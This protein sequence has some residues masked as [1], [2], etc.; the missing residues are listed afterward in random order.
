MRQEPKTQ[1]S[2]K[3]LPEGPVSTRQ[4]ASQT[5]DRKLPPVSEFPESLI[6][7]GAGD[8]SRISQSVQQNGQNLIID[9]WIFLHVR[10]IMLPCHLLLFLVKLRLLKNLEKRQDRQLHDQRNSRFAFKMVLQVTLPVSVL[11]LQR[12]AQEHGTSRTSGGKETDAD[13]GSEDHRSERDGRPE[14][15][16]SS[17]TRRDSLTPNRTENPNKIHTTSPGTRRRIT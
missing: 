7:S 8:V 6:P 17:L 2:P 15:K 4:K 10:K 11:H 5:I 13:R 16:E 9:L 1:D 14:N 3:P 12:A